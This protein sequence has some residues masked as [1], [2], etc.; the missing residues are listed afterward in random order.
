MIDMRHMQERKI[1]LHLPGITFIDHISTI[2]ITMGS[3]YKDV[4]PVVTPL[5][6]VVISNINP[7]L[8]GTVI[9]CFLERATG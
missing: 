9:M 3:I 2:D 7:E 5:R 4:T 6:K 8:L 1:I